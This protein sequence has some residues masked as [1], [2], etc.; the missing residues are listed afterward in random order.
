[1]IRVREEMVSEICLLLLKIFRR[2]SQEQKSV[3]QR[4]PALPGTEAMFS[5]LFACSSR[6]V[7]CLSSCP[8]TQCKFKLRIILFM[9]IIIITYSHLAYRV[10]ERKQNFSIVIIGKC[11]CYQI[12]L[13][14]RWIFA[15][16]RPTRVEVV[17]FTLSK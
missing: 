13:L 2:L 15:H 5:Q 14:S 6:Q 3:C 17:V 8:T 16:A 12:G 10:S 7:L 9:S 4:P 1:M 11:I